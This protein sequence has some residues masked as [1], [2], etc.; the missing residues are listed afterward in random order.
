[1]THEHRR[2][3]PTQAVDAV[4]RMVEGLTREPRTEPPPGFEE[5]TTATP[6]RTERLRALFAA[7]RVYD[8][9]QRLDDLMRQ[10]A[11]YEPPTP[12]RPGVGPVDGGPWTTVATGWSPEAARDAVRRIQ[13]TLDEQLA[14][15][16]A[17]RDATRDAFLNAGLDDAAAEYRTRCAA[18]AVDPA[19]DHRI[20]AVAVMQTEF[21]PIDVTSIVRDFAPPDLQRRLEQHVADLFAQQR[22]VHASTPPWMTPEALAELRAQYGPERYPGWRV[23]YENTP[24]PDGDGR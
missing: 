22:A 10:L 24:E 23:E 1:M 6:K 11:M 21:G 5:W 15:A 18:V 2:A 20:R 16:R 9:Q 19:A 14:T 7:G 13:D 12:H 17:R 3:R 8:P 4:Q